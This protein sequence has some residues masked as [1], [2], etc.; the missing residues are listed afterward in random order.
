VLRRSVE[1]TAQLGSL[2]QPGEGLLSHKQT[3]EITHQDSKNAPKRT[4]GD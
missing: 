4:L 1:L 2:I 3:L